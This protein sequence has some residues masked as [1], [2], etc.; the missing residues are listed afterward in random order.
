MLKIVIHVLIKPGFQICFIVKVYNIV[1]IVGR[2]K[3]GHFVMK[4]RD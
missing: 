4:T 1:S 2:P 3:K